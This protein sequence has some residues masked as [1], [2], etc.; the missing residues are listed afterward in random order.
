MNSQENKE[1]SETTYEEVLIKLKNNVKIQED[2]PPQT[3]MIPSVT[4]IF[5]FLWRLTQLNRGNECNLVFGLL[6]SCLRGM[7][8]GLQGWIV[9]NLILAMMVP[10]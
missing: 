10:T 4:S 6:T 1:N 5:Y 3:E 8:Q 9:A 2:L 7:A